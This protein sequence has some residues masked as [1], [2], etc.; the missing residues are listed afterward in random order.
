M[1][2]KTETKINYVKLKFQLWNKKNYS[3]TQM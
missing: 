1:R 2:R 3:R